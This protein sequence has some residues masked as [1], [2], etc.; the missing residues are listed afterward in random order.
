MRK[1]VMIFVIISQVDH[2]IDEIYNIRKKAPI[3]FLV[4]YYFTKLR[5]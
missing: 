3:K 1:K 5:F 2:L 4:F